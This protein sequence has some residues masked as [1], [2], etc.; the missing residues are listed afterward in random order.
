MEAR[1]QTQTGIGVVI[2]DVVGIID[3]G[4]Y[5]HLGKTG[6]R[7]LPETLSIDEGEREEIAHGNAAAL[8]FQGRH[9]LG[10]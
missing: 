3:S 7:D 10:G 9:G 4:D 1:P 8:L 2:D 5:P 6:A